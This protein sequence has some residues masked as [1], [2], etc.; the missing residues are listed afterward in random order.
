[1]LVDAGG[2]PRKLNGSGLIVVNPPWKLKKDAELMLP[3]LANTL[4]SGSHT[5]WSAQW[6]VG[7]KPD[8]KA[9]VTTDEDDYS[10]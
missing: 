7:E 10:F 4:S 1:M 3:Y 9:D 2:D 6:L 5:A 8:G